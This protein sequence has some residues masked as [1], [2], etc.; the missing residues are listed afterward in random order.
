M[1]A[2]PPRSD[3]RTASANP[4]QNPHKPALYLQVGAYS[5]PVNAER[6]ATTVRN[7]HLGDVR[8]VD[9]T[10]NGKTIRR[11][12]LGP[13]RDVEQADGLTPKVRALG[14]GEP[15]VAIDD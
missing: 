11:V 10:V 14:L 1:A 13:L 6:A 4:P 7:A 8:V 2:A 15:R 3:V 12:R 5:D 9:S